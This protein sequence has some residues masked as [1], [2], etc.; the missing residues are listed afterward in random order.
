MSLELERVGRTGNV[1]LIYS[2]LVKAR[3]HV[4]RDKDPSDQSKGK[5]KII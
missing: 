1:K 2:A 3:C 4:I 5:D